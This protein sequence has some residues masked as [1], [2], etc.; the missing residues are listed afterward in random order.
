MTDLSRNPPVFVPT[1]KITIERLSEMDIN[2]KGFLWPENKLFI[3]VLIANEK[4]L[5]FEEWHTS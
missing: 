4:A 5:A 2:A 1:H 3:L